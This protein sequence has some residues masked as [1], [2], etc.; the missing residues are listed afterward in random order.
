MKN[1]SNQRKKVLLVD[2]DEIHSLTAELCLKDEYDVYKIKSGHEAIKLLS[3]NDFI[4]DL[5]ILDIIIPKMDGWEVF[6]KI[7]SISFL[8]NT[9]ILFLTSVEGEEGK[10]RQFGAADY[11]TKPLNMDLLKNTLKKYF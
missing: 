4:P 2:D 1:S 7:K 6:W 9:P 8:N 11:I 3:N 10:S 5:I